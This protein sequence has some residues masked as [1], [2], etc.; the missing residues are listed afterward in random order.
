MPDTTN[1]HQKILNFLE[2]KGWSGKKERGAFIHISPPRDL[3]FE[4]DFNLKILND[5]SKSDYES[6]NNRIIEIIAD[7][8]DLSKDDTLNLIRDDGEVFSVRIYDSHASK[9][10]LDL[11]LFGHWINGLKRLLFDVAS[12][13]IN[14]RPIIEKIPAEAELYVNNC[15]FL[16]TQKGSFTTR[17]LLPVSTRLKQIGLFEDQIESRQVN[18]KLYDILRFTGEE[19]FKKGNEKM[20]TADFFRANIEN[21]N[22]NIYRTIKYIYSNKN[23]KNTQYSFTYQPGVV[24]IINFEDVDDDKLKT[25]QTL[26]HKIEDEVEELEIPME[27]TGFVISLSI[28]N[29]DYEKNTIKL[30]GLHERLQAIVIRIKLEEEDYLKAIDAHKNKMNVTFKGK[31]VKVKSST[32]EYRATEIDSIN[33]EKS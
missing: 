32:N 16:Q 1:L 11:S 27:L 25:L 4:K 31:V 14:R 24:K 23:V 6:Y 8:Y 2:K 5:V 20:F 13:T 30:V 26:I 15:K 21:I 10:T 7:I 22:L 9:G 28:K 18:A 29:L 12:F 17:I 33:L 19:V 3:Y